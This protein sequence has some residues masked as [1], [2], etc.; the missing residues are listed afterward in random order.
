MLYLY[1]AKTNY[2]RETTYEKLSKLSG[3]SIKALRI[4]KSRKLKVKALDAYIIDDKTPREVI[5]ELYS[6]QVFKNEVFRTI[7]GY[8]GAYSVSNFGRV[9]RKL[10]DGTKKFV[11]P[12]F[13]KVGKFFHVNIS[14]RNQT[15]LKRIP[16]LVAEC[17]IGKRPQGY[18]V[19]HKNGLF[20]EN[21]AQ[22]LQYTRPEEYHTKVFRKKG[23]PVVALKAETMEIVG[24]YCNATEAAKE[25]FV[26]PTNIRRICRKGGVTVGGLRFMNLADYEKRYGVIT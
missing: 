23:I 6:K 5:R 24:E 8:G 1:D 22:N 7:E 3:L 21:H 9:K 10:K 16:T 12:I 2:K 13:N 18:K 19:T 20:Y 26:S 15:Y 17:F 25:L 11:L 14:W 4:N